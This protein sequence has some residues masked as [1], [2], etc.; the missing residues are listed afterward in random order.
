M[1]VKIVLFFTQHAAFKQLH[2]RSHRQKSFSFTFS[3]MHAQSELSLKEMQKEPFFYFKN[4]T[5]Q[6]PQIEKSVSFGS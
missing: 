4:L 3:L 5:S 6:F 1:F 2:F